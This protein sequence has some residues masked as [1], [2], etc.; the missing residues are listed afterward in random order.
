M[1]VY[2][3]KCR[4]CE[5]IEERVCGFDDNQV[6]CTECGEI[7]DRTIS[8]YDAFTY[9]FDNPQKAQTSG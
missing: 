5:L 3:Y 2:D 1:P 7:M 4:S 9:Y 8:D 6:V